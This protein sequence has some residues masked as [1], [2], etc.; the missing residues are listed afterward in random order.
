[1]RLP[2]L[3]FRLLRLLAGPVVAASVLTGL[4]LASGTPADAGTTVTNPS[5]ESGWTSNTTAT[6]WQMGAVGSG[7]ATLAES[8]TARSGA[9]SAKLTVTSLAAGGN[10]KVVVDQRSP[11]CA[12]TVVAGHQYIVSAWYRAN[13]AARMVVYYRDAAGVWHWW[14]QGAL[15]GSSS[16]WRSLSYQTAQVP[17]GASAL[18]FGP[19][20]AAIGRLYVDDASLTDASPA[21]SPSPTAT[22]SSPSPTATSSSPSPTA[23]TGTV[24]NVSTASQLSAALSNAAQGQTIVLADGTYTGNFTLRS[25]GT[26]SAPIRITGTRG[27]RLDGGTV[28]GGYVLHL[29]NANYVQVDGIT[30]T[31][32]QKAVVLDQCS[33]DVLTNLDV[34]HT[35]EEIILLRNYSSDNVVSNNEVH[36]AGNTTAGYGEGIYVGL[37]VSNWSS[38]G[39]SR[40]NGGPDTSD[41]NQ[42]LGNHVYDTSAENVDIKEGTTGGLIAN[43]RFDST[44]MSGANYA[45]SWVDIAGNGYVVRANTGIN[46]GGA[47]LDGYQT[48]VQLS[49]WA[50]NNYFDANSSSVNAAGYAFN[51]Q[52]SGTGNV[53][54]V[55]NTQTGA[56][57]GLANIALTP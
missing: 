16:S 1:M 48:H 8:A 39:Q 29:D 23:T 31:N 27:A 28:S 44:G 49:G 36:D 54:K 3:S 22:S 20:I 6:C 53:V 55:S 10:R 21:S 30:I 13:T 51:I 12:P 47:L 4:H 18:S 41:R 34:Y 11:S 15:S 38:S 43:N 26:A 5:F 32:A 35:G 37:A 2:T 50:K 42:I 9:R 33:H 56:A 7:S 40:T 57:K 25:S 45:D 46:P 14:A 24:V 17:N 52:T 19:A